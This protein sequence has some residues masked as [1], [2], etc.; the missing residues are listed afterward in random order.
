VKPQ[1]IAGISISKITPAG[2]L[3]NSGPG[4][5]LNDSRRGNTMRWAGPSVGII[6]EVSN[7]GRLDRA[8][9]LYQYQ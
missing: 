2:I 7:G 4:T 3:A 6:C 9:P 1:N 5:E 8:C